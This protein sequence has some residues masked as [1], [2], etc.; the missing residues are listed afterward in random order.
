MFFFRES[1]FKQSGDVARKSN[2]THYRCF[3]AKH[4]LCLWGCS[5]GHLEVVGRANGEVV[6]QQP[7]VYVKSASANAMYCSLQMM[8]TYAAIDLCKVFV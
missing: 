5:Q 2:P 3:P 1:C 7:A 4:A 6:S 8:L